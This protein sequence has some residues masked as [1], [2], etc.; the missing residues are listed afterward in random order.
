MRT[1]LRNLFRQVACAP[2]VWLLL[3]PSALHADPN[4][5][6]FYAE[7]PQPEIPIPA[8]GVIPISSDVAEPPIVIVCSV[9]YVID[10]A[11]VVTL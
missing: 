1:V 11:R 6:A 10:R 2:V 9:T 3:A 7:V 4:P 5:A 8:N